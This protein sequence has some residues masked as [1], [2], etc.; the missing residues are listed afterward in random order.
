MSEAYNSTEVEKISISEGVRIVLR[1]D[2]Y[3]PI[4]EITEKVKQMVGK[5]P[6]RALV[7]QLKNKL[8]IEAGSKTVKS[9]TTKVELKLSKK[10]NL[11]K[12]VNLN[13]SSYETFKFVH[14]N[15]LNASGIEFTKVAAKLTKIRQYIE[16]FG[17]KEELIGW[18]N[19][20]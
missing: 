16:E 6:S 4:A 3:L 17:S 7:Y 9:K 18:A 19:L 8:K 5:A 10:K 14:S 13:N 2:F 1:K 20:I 11:K 12:V 15:S